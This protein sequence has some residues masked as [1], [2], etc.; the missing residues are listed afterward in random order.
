MQIVAEVWKAALAG[1]D[2][3]WRSA[4]DEVVP[5]NPVSGASK[6]RFPVVSGAHLKGR[7]WAGVLLVEKADLALAVD[8]QRRVRRVGNG[9]QVRGRPGDAA[10]RRATDMKGVI[11]LTNSVGP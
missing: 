5:T 6:M 10:I 4:K 9:Q 2:I 11:V 1:R 7:K 8:R 3:G